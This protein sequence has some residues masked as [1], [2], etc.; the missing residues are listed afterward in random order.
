MTE[1]KPPAHLQPATA[2]WWSEVAG[3]FLLESHQYRLLTLAAEAW[4]RAQEARERILADGAYIKDRFGQLR[5]HPA[6]AV[7]R[8]ARLAFARLVRE[9]ALDSDGP[10]IPEIRGRYS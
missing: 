2:E 5:G 9:L 10:S 8:D 7:E 6:L 4:D 3:A 1:L